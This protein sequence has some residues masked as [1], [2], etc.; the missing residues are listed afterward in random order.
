MLFEM[1]LAMFASCLKLLIPLL[2]MLAG[3]AAT[4]ATQVWQTGQAEQEQAGEAP[5]T[6]LTSNVGEL[7]IAGTILLA[8]A[9]L[10]YHTKSRNNRPPS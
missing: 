9:T 7:S 6:S 1:L 3:C 8:A 10:A 2:V 4:P 5:T